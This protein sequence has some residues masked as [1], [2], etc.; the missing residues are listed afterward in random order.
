MTKNIALAVT[1]G[2]LTAAELASPDARYFRAEKDLGDTAL[3]QTSA[4]RNFFVDLVA[5][6]QRGEHI[7]P[8]SLAYLEKIERLIA[9]GREAEAATTLAAGAQ[10]ASEIDAGEKAIVE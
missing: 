2:P 1:F 10:T 8:S 4:E 5:R 6:R 3:F 7:I 9:V